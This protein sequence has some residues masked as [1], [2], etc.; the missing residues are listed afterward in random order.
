MKDLSKR[1]SK[2][3]HKEKGFIMIVAIIITAFF[4]L[5]AVPF[6]FQVSSERGSTERSYQSISALSLAEAGV[7]RAIWEINYGDIKSW[8][9]SSSLRTKNISSFQA[10]GGDIIGN[11]E[12]RVE[13][14]DGDTPVIESTGSVALTGSQTVDRTVR[15]ELDGFL[16]YKFGAYGETSVYMSGNAMVDSYDSRLNDYDPLNP[17]SEGN[18]GTNAIANGSI[19]LDSNAE[20]NGDV[21]I[22]PGG[23]PN[24]PNVIVTLSSSVIN[25]QREASAEPIE[26]EPVFPPE[27]ITDMGTYYLGG[28]DTDTI[29]QSS[30]Y[31]NFNI[32]SNAIVTITG[33]ITL[34]VSNNFSMTSNS[35][36]II[37]NGSS[38][39]LY[40]GG[41]FLQDSNTMINNLTQDT[42]KCMVLAL[43]SLKG[44]MV[45]NS[46]ADFYGAVYAPG[47]DIIINSNANFFGA[48]MAN[49]IYASSDI[50]LHYDK[51]LERVFMPGVSFEV[52]SW[53]EIISD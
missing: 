40:V 22:G 27:G 14:P 24:D 47:A 18:I 50:R 7:E 17:G 45:W 28:S 53:Q 44:T 31:N 41:S 32:D 49:S 42:T 19:E 15:V 13:N 33:D 21:I 6:L 34:Y 39:T 10:S 46:N 4:L 36:L 52:L 12:I 29:S 11:I 20:I 51:A 8:S 1:N 30:E 9:G 38:L 2:N 48:I 25:G 43:S 26:M 16:P 35:H 5:L 3:K 23:D 37:P